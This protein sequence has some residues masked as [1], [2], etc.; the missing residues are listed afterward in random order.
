MLN[1]AAVIVNHCREIFSFL[2][3]PFTW[4]SSF[5][6]AKW[7]QFL[8]IKS[9]QCQ[10]NIFCAIRFSLPKKWIRAFVVDVVVVVVYNDIGCIVVLLKTHLDENF[11]RNGQPDDIDF[12]KMDQSLP[13][14][15][16]F[17]LLL[18]QFKCKLKKHRWC[19]MGSN[20]GLQDG[21]CRRIHWA[22]ATENTGLLCKGKY[23]CTAFWFKD[24]RLTA[25]SIDKFVLSF[26][27]F[28]VVWKFWTSNLSA[29]KV[30]LN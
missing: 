6:F 14:L 5:F 23:H 17:V 10:N 4:N 29:N 3:L 27:S 18:S 24:T 26:L 9:F 13:L 16:I 28:L 19:A 22:M 11:V 20:P 7:K 8:L 21:R 12:Y 25:L 2:L 30:S 1:A 15:F